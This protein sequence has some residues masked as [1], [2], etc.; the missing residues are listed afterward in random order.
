MKSLLAPL[1]SLTG[2]LWGRAFLVVIGCLICQLGLGFTYSTRP[3]APLIMDDLGLTRTQFSAANTPQLA[4]QALASP[5]VGFLTVRLGASRVLALSA[6]LFTA[7]LIYFSRIEGA[8]GLYI[9]IGGMG[10]GAAGMGDISVGHVV[11]QWVR[12]RRGLALG[13]VYTGSNLGGVL[14]VQLSSQ[15]AE[16]WSWREGLLA[17][18]AVS[19][20]VLLPTALI[21]VREPKQHLF[22]VTGEGGESGSHVLE[23]ESLNL[24]SAIRTR[25]FWILCATLFSFFFYMVA[26]LD[27]LVLFLADTGM[28]RPEATRYFQQAIGLGIISKLALGFIADRIPYRWA[29]LADYGLLAF[30]SFVLLLLPAAGL[31]PVFIVSYGFAMA[32]RDVVYPLI[33]GH[34]F[35]VRYLGEIYGAM[36]M[37]LLLGGAL[38]PIF[39]AA[40]HDHLDSYE[41]AFQ[42]FALLNGVALFALL[43]IRDERTAVRNA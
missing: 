28:S 43:F 37:N 30:S 29:L 39:A 4:V 12:K 10:L 1:R 9:A 5:L 20:L 19:V 6:A 3:L 36:M 23:E 25:S 31:L 8:I 7:V 15:V 24:K 2:D 34:C 18:A 22:N 41:L 42:G 17:M 40:I 16:A 33:I 13:L 38:G 35:G 11:S 27:H 14:M 26:M 32:A 21:L